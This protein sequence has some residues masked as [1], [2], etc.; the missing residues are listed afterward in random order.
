MRVASEVATASYW[1]QIPRSSIMRVFSLPF[2]SEARDNRHIKER[3]MWVDTPAS[4]FTHSPKTLT[5][6][7]L[8]HGVQGMCWWGWAGLQVAGQLQEAG[9]LM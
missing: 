7:L 2:E 9:N 5:M 1:A 3:A 6:C 8:P 4:G